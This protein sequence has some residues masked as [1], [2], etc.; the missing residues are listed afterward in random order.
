MLLLSCCQGMIATCPFGMA[1]G[2]A[3]TTARHD[4]A[5]F[6][7]PAKSRSCRRTCMV[8]KQKP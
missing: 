2:N 3:R 7:S 1:P 8:V 6:A 5:Q 4:A